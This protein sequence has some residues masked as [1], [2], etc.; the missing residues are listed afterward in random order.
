LQAIAPVGP[1]DQQH[2]LEIDD[3]RVRLSQLAALAEETAR[4][5]AHRLAGE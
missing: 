4:V 5:L 3:H 1:F 2:L